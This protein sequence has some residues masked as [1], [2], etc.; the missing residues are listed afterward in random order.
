MPKIGSG[1]C[2]L[3][4]SIGD[5]RGFAKVSFHLNLERGLKCVLLLGNCSRALGI[6]SIIVRN[7]NPMG[8]CSA[9]A[10]ILL[11]L[12]FVSESLTY[13]S[14]KD[15]HGEIIDKYYFELK[16]IHST[17]AIGEES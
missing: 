15:N 4:L 6:S 2:A 13:G 12:K 7:Q 5:L 3:N 14:S 8:R 9:W 10:I 1:F 11:P 17:E 16:K